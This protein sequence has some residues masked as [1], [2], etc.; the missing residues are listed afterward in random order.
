MRKRF[1]IRRDTLQAK[2][3][4][5]PGSEW[6]ATS[7]TGLHEINNEQKAPPVLIELEAGISAVELGDEQ[8]KRGREERVNSGEITVAY[9]GR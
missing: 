7:P 8:I 5:E 9:D 6:Y 3:K 2:Q 4:V 1:R